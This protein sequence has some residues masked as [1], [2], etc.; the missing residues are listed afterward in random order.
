[1]GETA[2]PTPILA[3]WLFGSRAE[4]RERAGS[5]TDLAFLLPPDCSWSHRQLAALVLELEAKG[6]PAPD[7]HALNGTA[8]AFQAEAVL[9]GRRIFCRDPAACAGYEAHLT[10]RFLDFEP[11]LRLQYGIQRRRIQT[12]EGL[13]PAPRR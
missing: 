3:V 13:G 1:M 8:L 12:G 11:I 6:V 9:R 10:T 7:L 5:D 4:G 2:A